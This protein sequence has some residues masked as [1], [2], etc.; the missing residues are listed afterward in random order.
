MSIPTTEELVKEWLRLDKEEQTRREIEQLWEQQN[1]S[2]LESRL[3]KRI[4]F[5]TAGLRGRMEAGFARMNSLIII[6]AS[7]GLAAY[8]AKTVP[9]AKSKGVVIGHDHRHNSEHWANL[10]AAVFVHFGFEVYLLEGL[11]HTPLVPFSVSRLKASCGVMVT[12]SH[13]PKE[14]NGYKVY[15][16]NAVQI[17]DPHDRGIAQAISENLDSQIWDPKGF[18]N[19]QLLHNRTNELRDAYFSYLQGLSV[20]K[21]L[22]SSTPIK[23]VSTPMHGVGYVYS[24][25]AFEV[26]GFPPFTVVEAQRDPDPEFPTVAFPNPEEKGE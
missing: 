21:S 4:S 2:E 6:Q 19:S 7:Q 17:I 3:R 20:S 8:V 16:E 9:D 13:N 5:G 18:R 23:F 10:I 26:F 11:V 15:W 24:A 25:K 14:D 1:I 12:A 22:N